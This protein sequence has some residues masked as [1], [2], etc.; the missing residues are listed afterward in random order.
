MNYKENVP[1]L[2]QNSDTDFLPQPPT[3]AKI[4]PIIRKIPP[5]TN[6]GLTSLF[7]QSTFAES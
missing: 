7:S 6:C 2:Q 4:L 3:V 5:A 1:V